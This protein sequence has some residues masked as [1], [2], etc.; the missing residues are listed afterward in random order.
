MNV[1]VGRD[2]APDE[3]PYRVNFFAPDR[4]VEGVTIYVQA[5]T[6]DGDQ[7]ATT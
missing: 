2:E 5:P 4:P 7:P 6:A 1:D 3:S